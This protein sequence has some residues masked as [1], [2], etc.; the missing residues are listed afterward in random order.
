MQ[1]TL[2]F[3]LAWTDTF[4]AIKDIIV[5]VSHIPLNSFNVIFSSSSHLLYFPIF[6]FKKRAFMLK[7]RTFKRSKELFK[8]T[9]SIQNGFLSISL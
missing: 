6:A 2:H 4:I 1:L 7:S 5:T 9:K 3:V 8:E